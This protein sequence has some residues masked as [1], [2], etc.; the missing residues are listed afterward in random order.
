VMSVP[1]MGG[2][3][4]KLASGLSNPIGIAVNAADVYWT[5][6]M[7]GTVTQV[8]VH[9]GTPTELA[10]GAGP[11]R[12]RA[13]RHERLLGGLH[14]QQPHEAAPRRGHRDQAGVRH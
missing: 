7:Q 12:D 1:T 6:T 8:P 14:V 10:S 9:G 2:T 4:T 3:P 11:L 13:R 5:D